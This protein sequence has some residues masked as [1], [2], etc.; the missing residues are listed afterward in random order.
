M[1]VRAR[2]TPETRG[3]ILQGLF[4]G[5]TLREAA[6]RARVPIQTVRN[7]IT[8][9]N[10]ESGTDH[11]LF[12]LAVDQAREVSSRAD[13]DDA[14]F[15]GHLSRAVRAGSVHA[16]RLWWR[17]NHGQGPKADA[18]DDEDGEPDPF[19]ALDQ[20]DATAFPAALAG[21]GRDPHGNGRL[22]EPMDEGNTL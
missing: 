16:M 22:G 13:M 14:E 10:A 20:L 11:A 17:V 4:A 12:A 2:F 1:T 8:R 6:E 15:M 9:G 3:A 19:S 7:W 5:L 18:D 21:V